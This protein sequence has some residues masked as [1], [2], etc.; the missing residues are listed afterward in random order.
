MLPSRFSMRIKSFPAPCIFIKRISIPPWGRKAP[1]VSAKKTS[2][3]GST[4]AAQFDKNHTSIFF[5]AACTSEKIPFAA[6]VCALGA[7]AQSGSRKIFLNFAKFRKILRTFTLVGKARRAFSTGSAARDRP[8][9]PLGYCVSILSRSGRCAPRDNRGSG[10]IPRDRRPD[11][12]RSRYTY[13]NR[14]V[15]NCQ[16]LL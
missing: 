4:L 1:I 10:R 6:Q 11:S 13:H 5:P 2:R 3:Q 8:W 7:R 14:F 9:R 15:I 16:L 12:G